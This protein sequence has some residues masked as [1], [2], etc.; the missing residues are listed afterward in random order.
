MSKSK[1]PTLDELR[2]TA[3]D[4]E[5]GR[6]M[7]AAIDA[8]AA[9]SGE[10]FAAIA[11]ALWAAYVTIAHAA[12]RAEDMLAIA[13]REAHVLRRALADARRDPPKEGN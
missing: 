7:M 4:H 10:D 6:R 8:V 12:G 3:P 9:R 11:A 13:E 5:P 1:S 2:R